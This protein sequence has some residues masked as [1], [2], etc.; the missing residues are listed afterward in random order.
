MDYY[1]P[2]GFMNF[3]QA[4]QP[5]IPHVSVPWPPMGNESQ[6]APPK[7]GS[8]NQSAK[9][10]SKGKTV[11]NLAD[12]NDIRTAKRLVFDPDEDER[13]VSKIISLAFFMFLHSI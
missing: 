7:N 4:G 10:I 5:F 2:G 11:I 9:N 3:L 12:G 6:S 8:E 13:L 1:P